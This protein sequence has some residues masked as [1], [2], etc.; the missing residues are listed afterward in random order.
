MFGAINRDKDYLDKSRARRHE[1]Y[2]ELEAKRLEPKTLGQRL[3]W[4]WFRHRSIFALDEAEH[5]TFGAIA[6]LAHRP[7]LW[8]W[9]F[10]VGQICIAIY[11][12]IE[13]G[14]QLVRH[15]ETLTDPMRK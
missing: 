13:R 15:P 2:A 9:V 8:C 11:R 5:V 6:A 10:G 1:L 4:L 12:L 7:D 3:D 14:R